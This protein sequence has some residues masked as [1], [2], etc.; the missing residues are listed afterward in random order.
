MANKFLQDLPDLI[1]KG[2]I[3][4]DTAENIRT[5]YQKTK[6]ASSNLLQIILGVLG[7]LLVGLGI[8]LI[9]AHNWD[10]F[11]KT[12]KAI[13]AFVPLFVAQGLTVFVILK[14]QSVK[15]WQEGVGVF[16]YFAIAISISLISQIY[17]INGEFGSFM[18]VWM[19]LVLP[20]VYI[21]DSS[22]TSILYIG[23]ITAFA[24][25]SDYS[26][27]SEYYYFLLLLL[28]MPFY[29]KLIKNKTDFN[30]TYFHHWAIPISLI[31]AMSIFVKDDSDWSILVY[32]SLFGLFYNLGK[33]YFVKYGNYIEN[34]YLPIGLIGSLV[35]LFI[36]SFED[37]WTHLFK[38]NDDSGISITIIVGIFITIIAG[39]VL[40]FRNKKTD[41]VKEPMSYAF[42]FYFIV[43]LSYRL[44]ELDP[45]IPVVLINLFI[46]IAGIYYIKF[47]ES[48]NDLLFLNIGLLIIALL[49]IMRFFDYDISFLI[50]GVIFI[51]LGIG[52]FVANYL[53]IKKR[54]MNIN[55]SV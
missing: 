21:L 33:R 53:M 18:F 2:I 23:G 31:I 51:L 13:L 19:L 14:K 10:N 30:S 4:V 39:L 11:P 26:E 55:K 8:L 54:N 37:I 27:F 44:L 12:F 36:G 45:I 42:I 25:S 46:L 34:A 32:M 38:G 40:F 24:V 43:F 50:R 48:K 52:F 29:Y 35:V 47:G 20:M 9:L 28:I 22:I 17:H 15:M 7:A 6:Q 3:T 49:I 5:Y 1:D 41:F 16:I